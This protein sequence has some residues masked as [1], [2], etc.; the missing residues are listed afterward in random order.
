MTLRTPLSRVRG[1]G[2]AGSGT[3]HFISI[4]VTSLALIPLTVFFL[5]AVI[6]QI[7]AGH[8]EAVAFIGSPVV[9][10]AFVLL[11]LA[12]AHHMR[13]GM[14]EIIVDYVHGEGLRMI[15]L[16]A[17]AVFAWLIAAAGVFAV[18]KIVFTVAAGS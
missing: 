13:L 17:N 1:L 5:V 4:R 18:L 9:A 10:I 15:A 16:L 11:I 12:T 2:S 14:Q 7:G 3:G 8:G 6:S